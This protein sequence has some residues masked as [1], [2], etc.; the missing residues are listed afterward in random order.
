MRYILSVVTIYCPKCSRVILKKHLQVPMLVP[1]PLFFYA[2]LFLSNLSHLQGFNDPQ[3]SQGVLTLLLNIIP[4][5]PIPYYP[6]APGNST[7]IICFFHA[8]LESH[9]PAPLLTF[10]FC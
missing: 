10:Q 4:L 2:P 1:S 7:K 9:P 5:I 3:T 8:A 6:R